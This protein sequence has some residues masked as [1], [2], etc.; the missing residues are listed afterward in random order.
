MPDAA[1]PLPGTGGGPAVRP[2]THRRA[3]R[4][5]HPAH[6]HRPGP[7]RPAPRAS[8]ST[9]GPSRCRSC[10]RRWAPCPGS[11]RC[12]S[13]T[14]SR[15]RAVTT[16]DSPSRVADSGR[17][18]PDR[19]VPGPPIGRPPGR[20]TPD[21]PP[22][23]GPAA[24]RRRGRQPGVVPRAAGGGGLLGAGAALERHLAAGRRRRGGAGPAAQPAAHPA[25]R[26]SN[27]ACS[28]S[29]RPCWPC[30]GCPPR[31]WSGT[32]PGCSSTPAAASSGPSRWCACCGPSWCASA[33]GGG[34]G[35]PARVP[36]QDVREPDHLPAPVGIDHAAWPA[37]ST[38]WSTTRPIRAASST[39]STA[40]STTWPTCPSSRPPS[41]S[42]DGEQ[43]VLETTTMLRLTDA[44]RLAAVD[45]D[46][47]RRPELDSRPRHGWTTS[48]PSCSTACDSPSSPMSGC[49]C[50]PASASGQPRASAGRDVPDRRI[51]PHYRYSAPVSRCRN[52]AHLRPRDTDRQQCLTSDLMVE[53]TPTSWTER[54][55]FFGNPVASFA[56]DGPF[57]ELTVIST[58]SVS[59]VRPRTRCP[60]PGRPGSRPAT[61]WPTT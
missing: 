31:T 51:A 35:P 7:P 11:T 1:T 4:A 55:D 32:R 20:P 3:R 54:T 61:G 40:C 2:R 13:P 19:A 44:A 16:P 47:G 14:T 21:R 18:S 29:S 42:G 53:P 36:A 27:P 24:R 6:P 43:L 52:E 38:C 59:V 10:C 15:R 58:S 56:V 37:R 45:P 41:A 39:S 49:R 57:D 12:P 46:T 33:A 17:R 23:A 28:A 30:P 34:R 48:W 5:G 26:A 50:W 60:P 8:A 9:A 22:G 25:G